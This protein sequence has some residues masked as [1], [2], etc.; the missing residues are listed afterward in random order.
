RESGTGGTPW[1]AIS[2]FRELMGI[3]ED[4]YTDFRRLN[5]RVIKGPIEELNK[6]T[7]LLVRADFKRSNR[8]VAA[9]KL[10]IWTQVEV[11]QVVES[12]RQLFPADKVPEIVQDLA[13]AGVPEDEAAEVWRQGW[14][15]VNADKRSHRDDF[16]AYVRGKIAILDAKPTGTVRNRV[17]FLIEAI[18]DNYTDPQIEATSSLQAQNSDAEQRRRLAAER[19]AVLAKREAADHRV[20][21]KLIAE[22]PEVVEN[23]YAAV[24]DTTP[25][26]RM[27]VERAKSAA[28]NYEANG[29]L[30]AIMDAHIKATVPK[31]FAAAASRYARQLTRLDEEIAALAPE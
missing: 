18:R 15:Y 26:N 23:A 1:I 4:Q 13:K 8:R 11:N 5:Q 3:P 22:N 29:A 27:F 28:E 30:T 7:D 20:C 14:N 2:K 16:V 6:N 10:R 21:L 31:R 12:Q 19:E 24:L 17:G 25:T 9:I